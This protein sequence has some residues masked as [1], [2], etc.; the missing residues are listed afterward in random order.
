MLNIPR[1]HAWALWRQFRS[2]ILMCS[3]SMVIW[4]SKCRMWMSSEKVLTTDQI[5][6]IINIWILYKLCMSF[7]CVVFLLLLFFHQNIVLQIKEELIHIERNQKTLQ[8]KQMVTCCVVTQFLSRGFYLDCTDD[9]H[10]SNT[11]V[12]LLSLMCMENVPSQ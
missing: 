11:L 1:F 8:A 3:T 2:F 5:N 9:M 10:G 12:F 4:A 6:W 7:V